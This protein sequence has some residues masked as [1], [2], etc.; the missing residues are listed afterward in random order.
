MLLAHAQQ[1]QVHWQLEAEVLEEEA[2][3]EALVELDGDEDGLDRELVPLRVHALHGH[4]PGGARRVAVLEECLPGLR[5][6]RQ[7]R[8]QQ[9][10]EERLAEDL[11]GRAAEQQ[12]S[13]LGPLRDRALAVGEDE[14]AA[15][16]LAQQR[17][18]R[19][20]RSALGRRG[21]DLVG[22]AAGVGAH[23]VSRGG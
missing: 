14:V 18:E 22:A 10:A 2:E 15:D 5:L 12:L 21:Q 13:R 1:H 3:V 11:L 19:V 23:S 17:V 4:A 6:R 9:G 8:V 16:D 7:R 20:L